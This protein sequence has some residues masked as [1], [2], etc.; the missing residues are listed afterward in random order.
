[1]LKNKKPNVII[2]YADDLGYGDLSCYGGV[3]VETPNVDR[4][5]ENG[6]KFTDAYSTSAVCTP[7]RYSVITGEYPFRNPETHILPGNAHCIIKKEKGTLP[8]VFKKAG[9]NT[10]VIGKWHLGLGEDNLDWNREITHTPNDV[11]FDYSYIFPATNDRVPCV[12][13]KNR[14]VEN[15]EQNDPIE[16]SYQD[17]CPYEDI[18]TATKNPEL[19]RMKHS[20]GHD[21]SIVNGVGR[22]GYMRGGEKATWR[23]EDLSERFS[24]RAK[25][26]ITKNSKEPFFMFYALHQPHVPRVPN[27]KFVGKTGLGPRGDVIAEMDWCIGELVAHLEKEGLLNDTIIIFSSDNGPVL[28]DGYLDDS[29][30]FNKMLMHK[31]AGPL[32]G[33]KYSKFEGG[34]RIPL[35]V[36][37]ESHINPQVS[38]A[39]VSQVDFMASFASMLNIKLEDWAPDSLDIINAFLGKSHIGR[40]EILAEAVNKSHFLRQGKWTYLQPK[41]DDAMNYYTDIELGSSLDPQLY[42]M[43]YDIG[44]RE[45]VAQLHMDIVEK[46]DK[47]IEEIKSGKIGKGDGSF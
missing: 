25:N 38:S 8:K 19:L 3:G 33:G 15:L 26:F 37:W 47:R 4:L 17:E 28:D 44:Q 21:Q 24:E 39:L 2:V 43:D 34:T 1:M 36:S 31:P 11:G 46:M 23:D 7:A 5:L 30:R 6:V 14:M 29:Q 40:S 13:I 42:N 22:I 45:N 16:V 18:V 12:Y 10:A 32:R 20:H 27:P 35:I 41:D 9:Y